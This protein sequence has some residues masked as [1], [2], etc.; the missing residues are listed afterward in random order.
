MT[1]SKFRGTDVVVGLISMLE[2]VFLWPLV[3]QK[4]AYN[5]DKDKYTALQL[6]LSKKSGMS[7]I[8]RRIK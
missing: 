6:I 5:A 8:Y 1:F 4:F 3:L 2:I 7:K